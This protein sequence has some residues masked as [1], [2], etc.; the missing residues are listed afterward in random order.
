MKLLDYEKLVYSIPDSSSLITHSDL[1]LQHRGKTTC[2]L[3][4]N[5]YFRE[6][7]RLQV[8]EVLDFMLEDFILDYAYVVFRKSEKLYYYDS[9]AHPHI[10][11]LQPTH[12]HHKH[13]PP[14]IKHNRIPAPELVFNKPNLPLIIKEIKEFVQKKVDLF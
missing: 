1:V 10:L 5:V 7:I 3:I 4:G 12:P 14:N 8:T 11:S 13:I 2:W 6:G 9:Q